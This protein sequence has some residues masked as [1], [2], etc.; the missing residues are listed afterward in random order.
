MSKGEKEKERGKPINRLL[1]LENKLMVTRERW[2]GG[3]AMS[4]KECICDEHQVM[5]GSV[6]SL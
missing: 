1:T 5:N 2:V 3:W 4:I 6:E